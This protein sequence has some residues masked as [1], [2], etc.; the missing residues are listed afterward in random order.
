MDYRDL[1]IRVTKTVVQAFLAAVAAVQ[2][3]LVETDGDL[4]SAIVLA[5]LAGGAS[6]IHNLGLTG[7][8]LLKLKNFLLEQKDRGREIGE[9]I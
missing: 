9:L 2:T 1:L 8:Q 6:L 4:K 3:Q 5:G 7:A